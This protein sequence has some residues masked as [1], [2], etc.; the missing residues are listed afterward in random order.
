MPAALPRRK[1]LGPGPRPSIGMISTDE[2]ARFAK[3]LRDNQAAL[4]RS[5]ASTRLWPGASVQNRSRKLTFDLRAR[6]GNVSLL[7]T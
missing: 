1:A 4:L 6:P 5:V 2:K 3:F 7:R